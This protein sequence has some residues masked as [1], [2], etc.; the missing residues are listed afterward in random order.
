MHAALK[1]LSTVYQQTLHQEST[2]LALSLR[3]LKVAA[4]TGAK[5]QDQLRPNSLHFVLNL[6]GE[7]LVMAPGTRLTLLPSTLAIFTIGENP[8]QAIATRFEGSEGHDFLVLS[9]ESQ[10]LGR[11]FRAPI[12]L[13]EKNLGFLRRWSSRE[14]QFYQ[15]LINPPVAEVAR[16]AWFQAKILELLS[17]H[18]F[19]EP[20]RREPLFCSQLKQKAHR[21]TRHALELLQG[22]LDEPLDLS[23][24]AKDVGCAPH[25][26]S[27]LVKQDTG[28]TLSLHLRA[29]R[30]ERA[31]ELL[32]TNQYNVTEVAM[33]VGYNSLSHFSK[34]F[35]EE[36]GLTPSAFLKRSA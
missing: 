11:L 35:V 26:L 2:P 17:L 6:R 29:F 8:G 36:Q 13:V 20:H 18:L 21:Y 23:N 22:R 12:P 30:V 24:L 15:D 16:H 25:Y 10:S 28:K 33:E 31:A 14:E 32:G 34:A 9:L 4:G 19:H 3:H 7:G 27:R 1:A 5:W